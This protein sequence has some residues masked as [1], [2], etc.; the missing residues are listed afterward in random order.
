MTRRVPL[1]MFIPRINSDR[2]AS[3]ASR[4][5]FFFRAPRE[6]ARAELGASDLRKLRD[7]GPLQIRKTRSHGRVRA[8][9]G[10]PRDDR[11]SNGKI[12][13]RRSY[14]SSPALPPPPLH[15]PGRRLRRDV[16]RKLGRL[17][18]IRSSNGPLRSP[19]R[20][21]IPRALRRIPRP[22]CPRV[23]ANQR[24]GSR[25]PIDLPPASR[26]RPD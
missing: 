24:R 2:L 1:R 20:Y 25:R 13:L 18:R 3:L 5:L 10:I 6:S 23:K 12:I 11:D 14:F 22:R 16:A 17:P 15:A 9:T 4:F 26:S 7:R 21:V 19:A 8:E